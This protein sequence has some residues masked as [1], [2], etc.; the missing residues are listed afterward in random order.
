MGSVTELS[1]LGVAE[2]AEALRAGDV[3]AE[4]LA[5]ALLARAAANAHLNAFITLDPGQVRAAARAADQRRLSGAALGPLH[6]VPLALKDNLDTADLPT[7]GGTPGLKSNRP[8]HDAAVVEKLRAAGAI[9]MG[10][11]NMHE[12]AYGIT[13]NNAAFGPVRN[14]YAPARIP[15]GSSGGTAAAVAARLAPGGIGTDTGG[16]VRVPAAL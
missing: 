2:V 16:S 3:T 14:P 10:K 6:G 5:D 7:T 9:V 11:C 13:S 12:L 15:G 4:R 8:A 1:E